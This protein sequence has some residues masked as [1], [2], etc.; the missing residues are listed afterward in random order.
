MLQAFGVRIL[1]SFGVS[2]VGYASAQEIKLV[3]INDSI[4]MAQTT[5]NVW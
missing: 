4:Y 1:L 2:I 5:S 3:K